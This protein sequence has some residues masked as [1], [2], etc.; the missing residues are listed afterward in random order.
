RARVRARARRQAPQ[1][2]QVA[3]LIALMM[4]GFAP[5]AFG[6]DAPA[7]LPTTTVKETPLASSFDAVLLTALPTADSSVFSVLETMQAEI[8]S[9]RM[10]SGG[11]GFGT[12]AH[13]SALGSSVTQA[14]YRLGDADITDPSSGSAPLM[15]PELFL[16]KRLTTSMGLAA[17]D[18]GTPGVS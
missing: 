15:L 1:W 16:L 3:V 9:H 7:P 12:A 6:Q 10:S 13:F 2:E 11:I 18:F 8:A 14:R 17:P 4:G 5:H